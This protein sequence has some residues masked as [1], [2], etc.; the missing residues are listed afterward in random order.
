MNSTTSLANHLLIALP[1]MDDPNFSGRIA[2][3]CHHSQQGAMGI[4]LNQNSE[5][6]LGEVMAQIGIQSVKADVASQTVLSGGPVEPERGFVLHSPDGGKWDSTFVVS[7]D[8][9]LT[10]SRDVLQAIALGKGPH[11]A[12]VALGYAGWSANQLESEFREHIWLTAEPSTDLIF[13]IPIQS[14]W[15]TATRRIGI[16]P[17]ALSTYGGH[18]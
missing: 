17:S 3:L 1:G 5:L 10:T 14:R 12:I 8:V 11:R 6:L 13:D 7:P 16:D 4:V 18:A 15:S 2:L 9:H